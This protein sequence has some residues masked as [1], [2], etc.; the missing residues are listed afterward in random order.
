MAPLLTN[1]GLETSFLTHNLILWEWL[2]KQIQHIEE[3]EDKIIE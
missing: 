2:K 3:T 1:K